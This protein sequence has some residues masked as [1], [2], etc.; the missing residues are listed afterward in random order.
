[1]N[2]STGAITR[3]GAQGVPNYTSSRPA[4]APRAAITPAFPIPHSALPIRPRPVLPPPAALATLRRPDPTVADAR[5]R[6]TDRPR[7]PPRTRLL[8]AAA[9]LSLAALVATAARLTP[10]PRGW[11]T[12]EQLG[13]APCRVRQWTGRPCPT[14]GMTTA[15][16]H[17][18]RGQFAAAAATN[19]GGVILLAGAIAAT[20]WTLAAAT[21]GRW[22]IAAPRLRWMVGIGTVW[23]LVTLLDWARRLAAG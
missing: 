18:V 1:M 17:A 19:L 21:T 5:R 11:G 13:A 3:S 20:A 9:G 14:C 23:L 22:W 16:A 8:A 10:D 2:L 6:V 15:W 12:H 7:L 4:N